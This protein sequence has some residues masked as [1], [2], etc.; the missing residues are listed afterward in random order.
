MLERTGLRRAV[1][2]GGDTSGHAT[3]RL[4]I[5]ALEFLM[6]MAPGSPLCRASSRRS[7]LDGLEIVLKGGQVGQVDFFGQVLE[8]GV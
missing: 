7:G 6:P 3:S 2:A 5:D 4:G 1:V 8:G